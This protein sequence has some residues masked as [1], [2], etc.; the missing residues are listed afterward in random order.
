MSR[1]VFLIRAVVSLLS[2]DAADWKCKDGTGSNIVSDT[3]ADKL[4]LTIKHPEKVT[5]AREDDRG[6]FLNYA[7]G[8][9]TRTM[10]SKMF[11]PDGITIHIQFAANLKEAPKEWLPLITAINY[12]KGYSVW[13]KKD[14]KLLVSFPGASNWYRLIDAKIQNLRDYDLKIIRGQERVQVLLDNKVVAFYESEGK[15]RNPAERFTFYLGGTGA[16][17]FHGNIYFCLVKPF[18]P[19]TF[20]EGK[21]D[22]DIK[23]NPFPGSEIKM[24]NNIKDPE[25]TVLINDF[26]KFTPEPKPTKYYAD[27]VGWNLR[28]CN[29]FAQSKGALFAPLNPEEKLISYNPGVKGNYDVYLGLRITSAITD[30]MVA[31]P[32]EKS[33]YCVQIGSAG[34][35]FH[36][37]T[38]V[39]IAKNVKMDGGRIFFY[40]GSRMFLGYIKLLPSS[41]PRKIDYPVWKCVTLTKEKRTYMDMNN[42]SVKK[43]IESGFFNERIFVG[44]DKAADV[45]ATS[46]KRGYVAFPQDWM[47][48][49]FEHVA[50]AKDP[51]DFTLT[52]KAAQG[53]IE[54][55]TLG[56]H[57]LEDCGNISLSGCEA[58][59]KLGV[60]VEITT[61]LSI[62][63]K[64]TNYW[65]SSEFIVGPQCLERTNVANLKAGKTKQFWLTLKVPENLKAGKYKDI[66]TLTSAKG[67]HDI[68]LVLDVRPFR[69]APVRDKCISLW[70]NYFT[71]SRDENTLREF[72][73]HGLNLLVMEIAEIASIYRDASGKL[74]VSFDEPEAVK[75]IEMLKKYNFKA[76]ALVTYGRLL[77]A[78]RN[79]PNGAEEYC[80][81]VRKILAHAKKNQWPELYFYT[82]DE[83]LSSPERLQDSIWEADLL[84]KCNAKVF[85]THLWYKTT[86]P[87]QKEVDQLAK[88]VD[89]FV[90]RYNSRSLWY[91]DSWQEM[92]DEC[93]RRGTELWSYN[94][95]GAVVFAQPAMKRFSCGWFFRTLGDKARGQLFWTYLMF[96]GSPYTDLDGEGENCKTDWC[97]KY[98][99]SRFHK[100]GFSI[101]YEAMREGVDDLRYILTLEN[102]IANAKKRGADTASAEKLLADLKGSFDLGPNFK[103]KSVFL[104]SFFEKSW[105]ENGKRYCSGKFNLPNGWSLADY[106]SA[107]EKIAEEIIR[108]NK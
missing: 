100:G 33:I 5:W 32:D 104:N 74:Q 89:A 71:L 75:A 1:F 8:E 51:G 7:G 79:A 90:V 72:S 95:D 64:T 28:E 42:E 107:R 86:R 6:F 97:Y 60:D 77:T 39:L 82:K 101:D 24:L 47:D 59:K 49:C 30:M 21:R 83:V 48:L 58:L 50:P 99:E 106:H 19:G 11:F 18:V 68:P 54:P 84:K 105:V 3:S 56:V 44:P 15:T 45:R 13:V 16:W 12:D 94:A 93:Q 43:K 76:L 108:L 66:V 61:I 36:P 53:E 17:P 81:V 46:R 63:K 4:D 52:V 26:S 73:E 55:V 38:E 22:E 14:G 31:V 102:S 41:N 103:K 35:K 20:V 57:G 88:N 34:Y 69:L 98:P 23:G 80:D 92:Q 27:I 40:P 78:T 2:L 37:N 87:F 10:D 70:S 67:K 91:V 65:G 29:F 9:V 85:N 25:G 62:P 96:H